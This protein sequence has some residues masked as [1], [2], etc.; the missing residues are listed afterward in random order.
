MTKKIS[1]KQWEKEN[2]VLWSC[3][4]HGK[5]TYFNIKQMEKKRGMKSFV[6]VWFHDAE[7]RQEKMWVRIRSGSQTIGFGTLDNVPIHLKNIKLND[8]VHYR[9]D[10]RGITRPV[11][12][13]N[14][15]A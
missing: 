5:E 6:Y 14:A 11:H 13:E 3:S 1:K 9:T 4:K 10:R 2:N 7:G 12:K 8:P 15:D